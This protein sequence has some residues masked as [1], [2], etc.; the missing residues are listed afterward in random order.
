MG[1]KSSK[2]TGEPT[3]GKPVAR[4]S[5]SKR[6]ESPGKSPSKKLNI[7]KVAELNKHKISHII[8]FVK[9]GNHSMVAGLT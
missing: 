1:C 7:P 6:H 9:A 2:D 3:S 5:G 8:G 4:G